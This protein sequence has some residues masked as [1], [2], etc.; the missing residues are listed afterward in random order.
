MIWLI[1]LSANIG[2]F[3]QTKNVG[4][5]I[6]NEENGEPVVAARV[7]LMKANK[8]LLSDNNGKFMFRGVLLPD[9]LLIS[10]LGYQRLTR[11]ILQAKEDYTFNLKSQ[12]YELNEV[13][14]NTGYQKIAVG[15][16]TGSYSLIDSA[17]FNRQVGTDVFRRLEGITP[18]LLYDK[19]GGDGGLTRFNIRGISSI[20]SAT[21]TPLIVLDNFPYQGDISNINPNDVESITILKDAAASAI[22]GTRAGNGVVVITTKSGRFNSPLNF[23]LTANTTVGEKADAFSYPTISSADF[24]GFEKYLYDQGFYASTIGNTR[25]RP[26]LSP[27]IELL[28]RKKA[29]KISDS[30]FDKQVGIWQQSDGRYDFDRYFLRTPV[31]QQYSLNFNG[32]GKQVNYVGSIGWDQNASSAIGNDNNRVSIR[33]QVSLQPVQK[34]NIVAGIIYTQQKSKVNGIGSFNSLRPGGGKGSYYPYVDLVDDGGNALAVERDYRKNYLD[35]AGGGKLLDW[36][37]RPLDEIYN[38]DQSSESRDIIINAQA[39]Y[40]VFNFLKAS[41][42]YR[43]EN[44]LGNNYNNQNENSNYTRTL[45]NRF[46][47]LAGNNV[48]RIIPLG[49]IIDEQN[50][51]LKAY[52]VRGQLDFDHSWGKSQVSALVGGEV[53]DAQT[54]ANFFRVYGF[55][56]LT[57]T[58]RP[59]DLVNRYAAF[60]NLTGPTTIP[61]VGGFSSLLDR[62]FSYYGNLNYSYDRQYD[63][64]ISARK[65]AS[66]LFGVNANQKGVPLGSL[67]V[68]WHLD[69]A[70]FYHV[71]WLPKLALRATY[72]YT[73]NVNKS[74]SA[75][76]TIRYD[77]PASNTGL[78]AATITSPPN[79]DLRWEQVG[80]VNLGIDFSTKNSRFSGSVNYFNKHATDLISLTTVDATTGGSNIQVTNNAALRNQGFEAELQSV[81]LKGKFNWTSNFLFSST[82]NKVLE[83][84]YA[85]ANAINYVGNGNGVTPIVGQPAYGLIS[86]RSA[87][88]DPQTGDPNVYVGG[89]ANKDYTGFAKNIVFDDLVFSGPTLPV[90]FGA[91]RNN[92]GYRNFDLSFNISYKLGYFYRR[93]GLRYGDLSNWG[94]VPEYADRWQQTGDELKTNV[95][96]LVYPL[97][98][99]RDD[100]YSNSDLLVEKGDHIRLQDLR[101]G[102]QFPQKLVSAVHLRSVNLF[103][104]GNDLGLLWKASKAPYDPEYGPRFKP[105]KSFSFGLKTNF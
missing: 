24:L 55:D 75:L 89:V 40:Q 91:V 35:S 58:S 15:K 97:N 43:Y 36:S 9:T 70:T 84:Y 1:L 34:L 22:W 53:R 28:E 77:Q 82:K 25:N 17:V 66:N 65:D 46:S 21:N 69:K 30:D 19:R 6:I 73:G 20:N 7:T 50:S 80:I 4:G 102:Y 8:T 18:S 83:Y 98:N 16:A 71:N 33:N 90:Y 47:Q 103:V 74:I 100:A 52:N 92:F 3:A 54:D 86:F 13:V 67:G 44:S 78:Q 96:S 32:G 79:P 11:L 12:N 57:Y 51:E 68:A 45:I 63:L 29:G 104:I 27:Y 93:A 59:V 38:N 37:Y 99:S 87:G 81:N 88:L 95:P 76:T 48:T 23:S 14:V 94:A 56:Q 105:T 49:G 2:L 41:V 39:N 101:L 62:N 61:N 64:S 42:Q 26:L 10:S 85:P 60:G 72:G 31:A 5:Q